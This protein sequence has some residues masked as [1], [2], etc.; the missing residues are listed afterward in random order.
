M[1]HILLTCLLA[2]S[3]AKTAC[4]RNQLFSTLARCHPERRRFRSIYRTDT[5]EKA[6]DE[7]CRSFG[8]K[9][10]F[11]KNL[12]PP[13]RAGTPADGRIWAPI[14]GLEPPDAP[15]RAAP[16]AP[17]TEGW[18]RP[19]HPAARA[20]ERRA[21]G[22]ALH[23]GAGD[24]AAAQTRGRGLQ[25]TAPALPFRFPVTWPLKPKGTPV[26]SRRAGK[27]EPRARAPQVQAEGPAFRPLLR[28]A[29]AALLREAQRP[30]QA[31]TRSGD[32]ARTPPATQNPPVS[33]T[34]SL[35]R[36]ASRRPERVAAPLYSFS[37]TGPS[38]VQS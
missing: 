8:V 38:G 23:R 11:P 7:G 29:Q 21:R 37:A 22:R 31:E 17:S 13:S 1:P 32:Q 6:P 26:G 34:A 24:T 9:H 14:A 3:Y 12:L 27:R 5:E 25:P 19:R 35:I 10:M 28:V 20:A 2:T 15:P 30:A 18:L 4:R 16:R 33:A 36:G